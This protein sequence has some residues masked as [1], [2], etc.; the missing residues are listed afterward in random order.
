[1]EPPPLRRCFLSA[2]TVRDTGHMVGDSGEPCVKDNEQRGDAGQ[3]E[4]GRQG[5]LDEMGDEAD[6][7]RGP[8]GHPHHALAFRCIRRWGS[9]GHKGF[10]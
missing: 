10:S 5:G 7:V 6:R 2:Q 1:M 4:D 8:S 9:R 3:Q